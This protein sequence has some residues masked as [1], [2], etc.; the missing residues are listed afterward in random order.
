MP[1]NADQE[2][3]FEI[4]CDEKKEEYEKVEI[5]TQLIAKIQ[6]E[7]RSIDTFDEKYHKPPL[8]FAI[9]KNLPNVAK[10]LLEAKANP[11]EAL[12]SLKSKSCSMDIDI[13]LCMNYLQLATTTGSSRIVQLL[14]EKKASD[15][16]KRTYLRL[17]PLQIAVDKRNPKTVELLINAKADVNVKNDFE[18]TP[19]FTSVLNWHKKP[20][21]D[22][23][24]K[25]ELLAEAKAKP[26]LKNHFS[27]SRST[28]SVM[29]ELRRA[30]RK[31]F[32]RH[33][34]DHGFV[35]GSAFLEISKSLPDLPNELCELIQEYAKY[36]DNYEINALIES[37]LYWEKLERKIFE[38]MTPFL[39][40]LSCG[41]SAAV[42]QYLLVS[43]GPFEMNNSLT[44]ASSGL[45]VGGS[46]F[47]G[48]IIG[49]V[50][51]ETG[52]VDKIKD[53]FRRR[54]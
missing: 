43:Y 34:H 29:C 3:L 31:A 48:N 18:E 28:A 38:I 51:A 15:L 11:N 16:E 13:N 9:I 35:N 40:V 53:C 24:R 10:L 14:L 44:P 22:S 32:D 2:Q 1:L 52:V 45:L 12:S 33:T 25:Y 20:T 23:R 5:I 26:R 17:T 42:T 41:A 54:R 8:Y 6:S 37:D 47:V 19:L 30:N 27:N 49:K 39:G 4:I 36:D 50:V 46:F 21:K 7:K